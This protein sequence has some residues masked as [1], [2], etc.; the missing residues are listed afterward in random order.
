MERAIV[1]DL[2][3]TLLHHTRGY[4]E[5]LSDA[6][7]A[8]AGDVREEWLVTYDERFFELFESVE[9]DPVRRA[10]ADLE[11]GPDSDELAES[12]LEREVEILRPPEGAH[13]D[14]ARLAGSFR[15]GVVTN[16]VREWQERKLRAHDLDEHVDALV[17]SYEAGEHKP[18]PGPFRLLEERLPAEAYAMVGDDDADVE[19]ATRAGWTAHRYRGDGFDDLPDAIDWE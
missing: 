14:L 16:G 2:D 1:F 8:V 10:F 13:A 4:G 9:P 18:E 11:D 6:I 5:I 7:E 15:I 12:L 19:G 3:G 17:A